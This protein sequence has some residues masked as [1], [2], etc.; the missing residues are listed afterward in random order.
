MSTKIGWSRKP[1][2][3][4][5]HLHLLELLRVDGGDG[6]QL[7]VG[8][9]RFSRGELEELRDKGIK[10]R[11]RAFGIISFADNVS[12]R[13]FAEVFTDVQV[14]GLLRHRPQPIPS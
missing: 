10:V 12:P 3:G 6:R 2:D 1:R 7:V 9:H 13:L 11:L 4:R 5:G 8:W 14:H